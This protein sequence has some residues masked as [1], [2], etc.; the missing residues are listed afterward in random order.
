MEEIPNNHLGCIKL[1]KYWDKLPTSTGWPEFF[2]HCYYYCYS[3]YCHS[4]FLFLSQRGWGKT[5]TSKW[6]KDGQGNVRLPSLTS[7]HFIMGIRPMPPWKQRQGS[8]FVKGS[9][10]LIILNIWPMFLWGGWHW[11]N[12]RFAGSK[13]G[14]IWEIYLR[15]AMTSGGCQLLVSMTGQ[16]SPSNPRFIFW[17]N[18]KHSLL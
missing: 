13:P 18:Q 3:Y 12:L 15:T 10:W 9:W 11:Q 14:K 7:Q 6:G 17:K 16:I 5:P 4:L 1:S 2:H 8:P